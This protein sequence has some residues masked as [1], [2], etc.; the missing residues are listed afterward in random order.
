MK[1]LLTLLLLIAPLWFC[2]AGQTLTWSGNTYQWYWSSGSFVITNGV[3]KGKAIVFTT[4]TT[5]KESCEKEKKQQC[6]VNRSYMNAIIGLRWLL[7]SPWDQCVDVDSVIKMLKDKANELESYK[8]KSFTEWD[9]VCVT[10]KETK[11]VWKIL[12]IKWI[13]KTK[14]VPITS[15]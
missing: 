14:F 1:T 2:T 3:S 12:P 11:K 5:L 10:T 15:Y 7:T 4:E 8:M 6:S 13:T 9:I